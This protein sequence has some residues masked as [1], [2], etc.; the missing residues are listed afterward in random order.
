MYV[1]AE[2]IRASYPPPVS[3][4]VLEYYSH[5]PSPTVAPSALLEVTPAEGIRAAIASDKPMTI[6]VLGD[7]TGNDAGEW[8]DLWSQHLAEDATVTLRTWK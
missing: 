6:S 5:P 1:A 4:K 7:S 2:G 3:D 8:V